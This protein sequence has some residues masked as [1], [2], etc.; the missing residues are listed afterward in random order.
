MALDMRK[1]EFGRP[2]VNGS[3][4]P[5]MERSRGEAYDHARV[6]LKKP[7]VL[8]LLPVRVDVHDQALSGS[9]WWLR[10]RPFQ[11]LKLRNRDLKLASKCCRRGVAL[12]T[13]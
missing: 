6:P 8:T 3:R 12:R 1:R 5:A 2:G 9:D 11:V 10:F 4:S 13:V 7:I